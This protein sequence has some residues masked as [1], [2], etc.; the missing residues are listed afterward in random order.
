M[1][2]NDRVNSLLSCRTKMVVTVGP[3]CGSRSCLSDMVRNGTDL[4]RLNFSHGEHADKAEWVRMIRAAAKEAN[5]PVAVLGDLQGPKIRTGLLQNEPLVLTE[6]QR[7]TLMPGERNG[8]DGVIAVSYSGIGR[9]IRAGDRVL[10][11][12]G[13][14]EMVALESFP[15]RVLCEVVRGGMLGERKGVNLPDSP[16]AV[17]PLT[18]KDYD[19]IRFCISEGFDYLALSFVRRVEDIQ[20]LR[21]YLVDNGAGDIGIVA[22]IERPEAVREFDAILD[23][24]DAIMVAR[25]DLGVEMRPERVPLIQKDII[26]K[27]NLAGVPVITATQMLESM[28]GKKV[29]TR[30]ET[31]DVANAI[32]DGTD[33]VMLSGETA[34]GRYPLEA[35][36]VLERVIREVEGRSAAEHYA[37][38]LQ[39]REGH[40]PSSEAIGRAACTVAFEVGA[41]AVVAFTQ[42]GGTALHVAK[43]RPAM[44]VIAMTPLEKVQHRLNLVYGV[45]PVLIPAAPNTEEQVDLVDR[46]LLAMDFFREGD[47]IVITMGSPIGVQGSTNMLKIHRLGVI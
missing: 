19:D 25:G 40:V 16:L 23:A 29:P 38:H 34:V 43:Y 21:E 2:E 24:A 17:P 31:S 26:R 39:T 22:K 1:K 5:Q 15:D 44:P 37:S 35:L 41:K 13:G 6:G 27:C 36:A 46:E 4:F 3:A 20:L 47:L 14:M 33:A 8:D 11:D 45:C 28:I 18:E 10:L 32:L 30:A 9:D 12:D 42:T 7:I